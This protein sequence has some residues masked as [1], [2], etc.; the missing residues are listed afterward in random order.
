MPIVATAMIWVVA[1]RHRAGDT[2]GTGEILVM[3]SAMI[4]PIMLVAGTSRSARN[5]V[6]GST[7][8]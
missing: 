5:P 1:E 2:L 7:A 8:R 4:A 3:M 6:A